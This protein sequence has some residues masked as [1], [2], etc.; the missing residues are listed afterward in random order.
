M[1]PYN[2]ATLEAVHALMANETHS[3]YCFIISLFYLCNVFQYLIC[4][5]EIILKDQLDVFE[6]Y[7]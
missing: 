1:S 5:V 4:D 7:F 3:L 6:D 2:A